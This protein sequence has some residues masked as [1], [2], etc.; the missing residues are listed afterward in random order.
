MTFFHK[1]LCDCSLK[2]SWT[3]LV[4]GGS[5]V[6]WEGWQGGGG[7]PRLERDSPQPGF[8]TSAT[9]A[10]KRTP[11]GQNGVADHVAQVSRQA[12]TCVL[13]QGGPQ[14]VQEPPATVEKVQET[15]PSTGQQPGLTLSRAHA[16]SPCLTR[17]RHRARTCP[18]AV[19]EGCQP[20]PQPPQPRT[21]PLPQPR[22]I[23]PL[24]EL[25]IPACCWRG[26]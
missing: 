16:L 22:T 1:C 12:R 14:D 6:E 23:P 2:P 3:H 4:L 10:G 15:K 13:H 5:H 19:T 25:S 9:P 26:T 20:C 11:H 17:N 24:R 8:Q 18:P 21:I 7:S